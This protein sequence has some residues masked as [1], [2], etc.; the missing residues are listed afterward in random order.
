MWGSKEENVSKE[1]SD[2]IQYGGEVEW[3][4]K[5]ALASV[6][7]EVPIGENCFSKGYEKEPQGR[8][9]EETVLVGNPGV[10]TILVEKARS[11]M[12]DEL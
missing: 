5:I 7:W 12:G 8:D 1:K 9:S 2:N 3:D 6:P 11:G 4:D 10:L